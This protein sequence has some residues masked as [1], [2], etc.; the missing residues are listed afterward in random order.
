MRLSKTFVNIKD[1]P[2]V[3]EYINSKEREN[4]HNSILELTKKLAEIFHN[5]SKEKTKEETFHDAIIRTTQ[6]GLQTQSILLNDALELVVRSF[7][8]FCHY[9][10]EA[11][12]ATENLRIIF[13]MQALS[14][15]YVVITT[16]LDKTFL[17]YPVLEAQFLSKELSPKMEEILSQIP[18]SKDILE[19]AKT[20]HKMKENM[21]FVDEDQ[22]LSSH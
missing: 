11:C 18:G 7:E 12:N 14:I 10:E 5:Y 8:S 19:I 4:Y 20:F 2:I 9:V 15:G 16:L 6:M 1:D 22:A 3:K 13:L 21:G 17:R